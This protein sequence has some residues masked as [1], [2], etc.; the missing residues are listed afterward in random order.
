MPHL[1]AYN[2][3]M[4]RQSSAKQQMIT[5]ARRLFRE[6][7][8]LGTSFADVLAESG[9]PR[10]SVYFH[11]PDGKEELA[12]EVAIAHAAES[13]A[14]IN[15][16]TDREPSASALLRAFVA[17]FRDEI[18]SSGYQEGCAVAPIILEVA[19]ETPRLA[20]VT[21][22]GFQDMITT[23]AAR[24]VD[25]GLE[26]DRARDLATL[27]VTGMEGALVV[28]RALQSPEPFE[29]LAV[30]LSEAAEPDPTLSA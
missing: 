11:F 17:H 13:V 9:A 26:S 30:R 20:A 7:G 14:V 29:A 27:A 18:V 4:P 1:L 8:Y 5:A 28:S 19:G 21:R 2:D 25:K 22:R 16:L 6:R 15:R 3:F 23:L 12:A 24:L 10:G